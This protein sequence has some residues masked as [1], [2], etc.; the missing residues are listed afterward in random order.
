V[1]ALV[2]LR[3]IPFQYQ[4]SYLEL[5]LLGLLIKNLLDRLLMVL[6]SDHYLLS[7]L[8]DFYHLMDSFDHVIGLFLIILEEFHYGNSQL[9]REDSFCSVN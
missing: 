8:L 2:L 1:F 7:G 6:N 9:R 3:S 4:V 5:L